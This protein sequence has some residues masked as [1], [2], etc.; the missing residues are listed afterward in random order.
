M[1]EKEHLFPPYGV[2]K[3]GNTSSIS[4]L[5]ALSGRN[6]CL[7]QVLRSFEVPTFLVDK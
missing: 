2:K 6:I 1:P 3:A 7:F 5:F 4:A